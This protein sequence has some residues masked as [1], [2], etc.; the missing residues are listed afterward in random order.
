MGNGFFIITD[1]TIFVQY[2]GKLVHEFD[3][4]LRTFRQ[5][6]DFVELATVQP[7]EVWIGNEQQWVNGKSFMG[8]FS[9]NCK[10]MLRVSAKCN[11]EQFFKFQQETE[12]RLA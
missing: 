7:F 11:E 9:L 5:V 1:K 8:V 2:G 12:Q 3:I 4:C 10:N 6:Q